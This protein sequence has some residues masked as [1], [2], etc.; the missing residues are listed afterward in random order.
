M[1]DVSIE[2]GGREM[3]WSPAIT[4]VLIGIVAAFSFGGGFSLGDWRMNSRIKRLEHDQVIKLSG[5][6]AR[7]KTYGFVTHFNDKD[8]EDSEKM[9]REFNKDKWVKQE[10]MDHELVELYYRRIP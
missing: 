9:I 3:I 10:P 7:H 4:A 2:K 5:Y 1:H 8:K 6:G